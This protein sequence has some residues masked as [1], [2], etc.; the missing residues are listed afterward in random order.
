MMVRGEAGIKPGRKDDGLNRLIVEVYKSLYTSMTC[1]LQFFI[2]TV[3][4][5]YDIIISSRLIL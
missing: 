5:A 1:E 4:S 2:Y 3:N